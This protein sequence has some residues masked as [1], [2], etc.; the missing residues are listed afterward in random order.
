MHRENTTSGEDTL[1]REV[2]MKRGSH[3]YCE[4]FLVCV[5]ALLIVVFGGGTCAIGIITGVLGPSAW[6]PTAFGSAERIASVSTF[7]LV[8]GALIACLGLLGVLGACKRSKMCL[9]LF[10]IAVLV[11]LVV[12]IASIGI[13]LETQQGVRAWRENDFRLYSGSA[14]GSA[15]GAA[16]TANL[17]AAAM[18][19]LVTLQTEVG[20]VYSFC[21][22]SASNVTSVVRVLDR[23]VAPTTTPTFNCTEPAIAAFSAWCAHP[24][25]M[26][27]AH[28][29]PM[30]MEVHIPRACTRCASIARAP[31]LRC[32][33]LS[34][35]RRVRR[36]PR[37]TG[38]RATASYPP[39]VL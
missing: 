20:A 34:L 15:S 5:A 12:V 6:L 16:A 29:P 39:S 19:T 37:V 11:L 32:W 33:P 23:G 14:S 27:I 22:P 18:R 38:S 28:P 30:C 1:Q 25:P 3:G 13:V 35:S 21:A 17:T 24:P 31:R 4:R 10:G 26:C 2:K 8:F 9:N 36:L 7:S